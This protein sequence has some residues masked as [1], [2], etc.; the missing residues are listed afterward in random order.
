M[1]AI[2]PRWKQFSDHCALSCD[3]SL[4][5]KNETE[6]SNHVNFEWLEESA[7]SK[8]FSKNLIPDHF[9]SDFDFSS[10]FY[11]LIAKATFTRSK[12]IHPTT[13]SPPKQK[14]NVY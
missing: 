14:K 5:H 4:S 11:N 2:N 12:K 3:I 7:L 8:V 6:L 13:S 1:S 10:H 9:T